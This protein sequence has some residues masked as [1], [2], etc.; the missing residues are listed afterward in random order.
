MSWEEIDEIDER[1][2]GDSNGAW[3]ER[4][5]RIE[6]C[7][8]DIFETYDNGGDVV[9]APSEVLELAE[10]VDLAAVYIAIQRSLRGAPMPNGLDSTHAGRAAKRASERREGG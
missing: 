9:V 7:V 1:W 5:Q 4:Y 2:K 6:E 10:L 8:E 3:L